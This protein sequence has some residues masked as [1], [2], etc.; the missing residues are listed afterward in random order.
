VDPSRATGDMIL[1]GVQGERGFGEVS[2]ERTLIVGGGDV[3]KVNC[4]FVFLQFV[5]DSWKDIIVLQWRLFASAV[6]I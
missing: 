1:P 6:R 2:L 3:Y 4:A 5:D